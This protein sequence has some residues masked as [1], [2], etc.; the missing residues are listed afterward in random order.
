MTPSRFEVIF[1]ATVGGSTLAMPCRREV[2]PRRQEAIRWGC[3]RSSFD[4]APAGIWASLRQMQPSWLAWSEADSMRQA[5]GTLTSEET[6]ASQEEAIFDLGIS[7]SAAHSIRWG[8]RRNGACACRRFLVDYRPWS[9]FFQTSSL[10]WEREDEPITCNRSK[11]G[12]FWTFER[13][14][15][16][17]ASWRRKLDVVRFSVS[18]RHHI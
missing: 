10:G 8:R 11:V 18:S 6:S 5:T 9:P 2:S 16:L 17:K 13:A 14:A 1:A 7:M 3:F 15:M 12:L 4:Q